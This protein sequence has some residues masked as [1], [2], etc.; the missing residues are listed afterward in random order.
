MAHLL[1]FLGVNW[2]QRRKNVLYTVV[3][4]NSVVVLYQSNEINV[5]VHLILFFK[6]FVTLYLFGR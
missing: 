2:R 6:I 4:L 3:Y 1:V 5:W